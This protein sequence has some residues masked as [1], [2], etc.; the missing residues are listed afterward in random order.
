MPLITRCPACHTAFRALPEQLQLA[1]GRVRCGVCQTEFEAAA[2]VLIGPSMTDRLLVAQA[3]APGE[4]PLQAIEQAP[5]SP[6]AQGSKHLVWWWLI[7]SLLGLVLLLQSLWWTRDRWVVSFPQ[8]YPLI[9]RFCAAIDCPWT[10]VRRLDPL[11]LTGSALLKQDDGH[12][13]L[14]ISISNRSALPLA[15]PA[16][17]LTLTDGA[18]L[19]LV[20]RSIP[21]TEWASAESLLPGLVGP[22]RIP[23]SI[24]VPVSEHMAGYQLN[25]I[26]P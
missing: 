10:P 8:A 13:V 19:A 11:V 16:L 7:V 26:Y 14:E 9:E 21:G 4:L 17:E 2:H 5:W 12:F 18:G 24:D 22:V 25:L 15:V 3:P 6:K 20:R 23:M 1:N